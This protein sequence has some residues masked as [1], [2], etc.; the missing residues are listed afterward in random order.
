MLGRDRGDA[1]DFPAELDEQHWAYLDDYADRL[2][3][4][5]PT[6]SGAGEHTGSVH[7]VRLGDLATAIAFAHDEP[8]WRA[9]LYEHL[10]VVPFR[11]LLG[12]AM[13]QREPLAGAGRSWLATLRLSIPRELSATGADA[14]ASALRADRSLVLCGLLLDPPATSATGLVAAFDAPSPTLPAAVAT[15]AE[16]LGGAHDEAT[17]ERWRRGGR[18]QEPAG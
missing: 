18:D 6:L 1:G 10:E 4:R 16:R 15:L 11:N 8:Y 5:G 2:I 13:W 14:A 3:A 12:V 7:V 9:G 17:V